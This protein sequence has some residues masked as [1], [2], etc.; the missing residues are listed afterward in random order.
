M[1]NLIQAHEIPGGAVYGVAQKD[2]TVDGVAGQDYT[3]ALTVAAYK[4][5]TAIESTTAAYAAIIRQR[6]KKVED[7]AEI[8]A[9]LAKA[10]AKLPV[11][12]QSQNDSVTIDNAHWVNVT[13]SKYGITLV[14]NENTDK[15]TR[16]NLQ[17]GQ[18]DVQYALDVENN[19]LQQD[20]VAVQSA[21]SKRDN[22]FSTAAKVVKKSL[23][24]SSNTI[25][26]IT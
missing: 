7:L 6:R 25:S 15:M 26:N 3:S 19:D 9:I 16:G 11:K 20:M 24:A 12:D 23:A 5:A 13:A 10:V 14:F 4:E 17:T 21:I 2:Y 22:A 1:S 8:L 18:N